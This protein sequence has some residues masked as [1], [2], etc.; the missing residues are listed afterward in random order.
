MNDIRKVAVIGAG[1]MGAGIAAQ[2]A[3]AGIAVELLDIVPTGGGDRNAIAAGALE[4]MAKM[5][6]AP[7]MHPSAI[8]RVRAGNIEDHLD[9]LADAD[10]IVEAVIENPGIKRALYEKI[11]AK[12]KP[13]SVVSSNTSTIPL[14]ALTQGLPERFANDFIITHFFNPPRYMRLLEIVAGPKTRP[15]AVAA[16]RALADLKLGK[17]VVDARDTPGFIANRVGHLWL[18]ASV[19]AALDE[20]VTVEEADAVIGK[21]FGIPSTGVFG[22]ID[23]VGLD[24]MPHVNASMK[25]MLPAND[26]FHALVRDA[27]L[28]DRMIAEGRTGRKGKGGFYRVT[29]SETGRT[30]EAIDL[31]SGEYRA[32]SKPRLA[33]IAAGEQ[34]GPRA[35]MAHD[36]RG[37]RYG[38]RVMS[39]TLAYAASVA[40]EI[41]ADILAVDEAMRLGYAWEQGPFE[42]LDRIGPAWFAERLAAEGRPVPDLL[43]KVGTGTFYRVENGRLQ[44]FTDAG[45]R[46]VV[47]PAGVVLLAD[48][49]RAAKPVA[50]N[51]SASLWDVGDGVIC[52]EF[53]SRMNALDTDTIAMTRKAIE[54][55]PCHHKGLVIYNEGQNFSVGANI[56]LVAFAANVAIWNEIEQ[57]VKAGQ[58]TLRDLKRAPFPVVAAPSG[59]AL[60]GGCEFL[61][62]ADAIQAHAE[63]YAGLVE[64]G[65][66]LIPGWGGCKEMLWRWVN[67]KGVPRGPIP[68]MAQAFE[69]IAM[70]KVSRSAMQARDMN[71]LRPNDGVTMNRDRLLADAKAKVLALAKDYV[72]PD[73]PLFSLAGKTGYLALY[74]AVEVMRLAGKVTPHDVV[75]AKALARVLSG[76]DTDMTGILRESEL[77]DLERAGFMKLVRDKATLARLEHMLETGRPLRN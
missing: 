60:G 53:H 10:W 1:T 38:W 64:V 72:A 41:A 46:D 31:A 21:P 62:H 19:L 16:I 61:L 14:A 34:Q 20:G 29:K 47:R 4:R 48:I 8:K 73:E 69:H 39:Q 37:G 2:V 17:R 27:P 18:V 30:K 11:E 51:G 57:M 22:L 44:Q 76:G 74:M 36:D 56:G 7:F 15:A 65:V 9:R 40:P 5:E 67:A 70:A 12:R 23:L 75:V 3:N 35:L 50:R 59:M 45:Y 71:I 49:K 24:L 54:I 43:K 66:G 6:P 58:D 26:A 55:I 77:L 25:A 33:S 68:A 28:I 13:G 52:L 32:T 63:T 42:L